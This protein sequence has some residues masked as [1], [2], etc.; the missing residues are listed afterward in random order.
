[1]CALPYAASTHDLDGLRR[2][3]GAAFVVLGPVFPT[4][5]KAEAGHELGVPAFANWLSR[6]G[7]A[8]LRTPVYALGGLR[9]GR[10][11]ACIAAGARGV[12]VMGAVWDAPDP[13]RVVEALIAEVEEAHPRAIMPRSPL[14]SPDRR[15]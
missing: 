6:A 3:D 15:G 10:V 5:G 1:M 7:D 4:P 9:P 12:A 14:T 13:G 8:G 2:E 11:A